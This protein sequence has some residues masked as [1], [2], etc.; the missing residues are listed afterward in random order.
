LKNRLEHK[1]LHQTPHKDWTGEKSSLDHLRT[2][3]ALV[4]ARKPRKRPAKADHHIA[5]GVLLIYGAITK[6]V[7]YFDQMT[8]R[9]KLSTHHTIDEAHYGKTH[10]PPGPQILMDMGYEQQP[11]ISVVITPPTLSQYPLRSRHKI[12]TPFLCKLLPLPIN[13]FISA[14]VAVIASTT[15]SAIDRNNSV[16]VTFSTDPSGPSF[17]ETNFFLA[18]I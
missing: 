10:R 12:V 17:T 11:V 18:F 13:E 8:N 9:E 1:A 4:T 6:H 15:M 14:P 5:H 3:G 16:A 7:R 2:F